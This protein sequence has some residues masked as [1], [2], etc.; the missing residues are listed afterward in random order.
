MSFGL[1]RRNFLGTSLAGTAAAAGVLPRLAAAQSTD[2]IRIG[3]IQ[4]MSS[5]LQPFGTQKKRCLD[6]AVD[7]VNSKGGLLGKQIEL[8]AYDLQSNDQLYAQFAT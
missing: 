3:T 2:K 5:F 4:D 6:L 1:N 7:E 8:I